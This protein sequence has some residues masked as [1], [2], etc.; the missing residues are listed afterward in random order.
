MMIIVIMNNSISLLTQLSTWKS[1][2]YLDD[3]FN[4]LS[5]KSLILFFFNNPYVDDGEYGDND[6]ASYD[7]EEF[8]FSIN[9]TSSLGAWKTFSLPK[10]H[11]FNNFYQCFSP[12]VPQLFKYS[13]ILWCPCDQNSNFQITLVPYNGFSDTNFA[14]QCNFWTALNNDYFTRKICFCLYLCIP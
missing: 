5:L 10:I 7:H 14:N 8:N 4:N 13:N 11:I 1:F 9:S 3:F 12:Y 6:D 2:P